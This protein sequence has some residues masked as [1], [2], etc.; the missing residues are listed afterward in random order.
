MNT[1]DHDYTKNHNLNDVSQKNTTKENVD[2]VE[3]IICNYCCKM[4]RITRLDFIVHQNN[5]QEADHS[6]SP[7]TIRWMKKKPKENMD[8]GEDYSEEALHRRY[9]IRR[10]EEAEERRMM[11]KKHRNSTGLFDNRPP[12]R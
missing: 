4:F 3:N 7:I 10:A 8:D 6:D 1:N 12:T 2:N 11:K 5:C 9:L